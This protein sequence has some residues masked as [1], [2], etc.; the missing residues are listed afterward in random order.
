MIRALV[1]LLTLWASTA[2]ATQDGWPA[3]HDVTG[4]AANDVLNLRAAPD[5]GA[6]IVGT[7]PPDATGVEV[8]RPN[9]EQ[10]WGLVNTAE[11]TG[12]ASLTYLARRPGQWQG[13][14]PETLGCGGTEP[15]W[16]LDLTPG[17][18]LFGGLDLPDLAFGAGLRQPAANRR[19]RWSFRAWSDGTGITGIVINATC[20]DGMS[21][22][23]YGLSLDVILA[24][25]DGYSH[26]AGCCALTD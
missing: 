3:L 15:F 24:T 23:E 8:I 1:V 4:V 25:G 13:A 6:A 5:A 11:G 26:Y 12:W 16:S 21:D 7:L 17:A 2:L 22:R 14:L 19:D 10:T 9:P 20:T 18:I